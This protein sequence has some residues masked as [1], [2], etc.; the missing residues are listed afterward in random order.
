M[1]AGRCCI[2]R[3]GAIRP[4]GVGQRSINFIVCYRFAQVSK[5]YGHV[6]A[7]ALVVKADYLEKSRLS[8]CTMYIGDINYLFV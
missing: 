4:G 2:K 7:G 5:I 8:T 6:S 3:D 1:F